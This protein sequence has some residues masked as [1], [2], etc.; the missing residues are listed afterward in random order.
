MRC[1]PCN[2]RG[3]LSGPIQ[4][5]Y[6]MRIEPGVCGIGGGTGE[7]PWRCGTCSLTDG[8]RR[9]AYQEFLGWSKTPEKFKQTLYDIKEYS[10]YNCKECGVPLKAVRTI[11]F[12]E[13]V[14]FFRMLRENI[15]GKKLCWRCQDTGS[16]R[17]D[18]G[19][20]YRCL[21]CGVGLEKET[22]E[23]Y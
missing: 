5:G 15:S 9:L 23:D 21:E 10:L 14:L 20:W 12:T 1:I 17:G 3:E 18:D 7:T 4:S 2:G 8:E 6:G 11:S 13:N 16:Y 22:D 19:G